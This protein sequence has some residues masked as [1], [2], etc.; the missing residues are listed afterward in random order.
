MRR[1]WFWPPKKTAST[2]TSRCSARGRNQYVEA[3]T[4]HDQKPVKKAKQLPEIIASIP[5]CAWL[6]ASANGSPKPQR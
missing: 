1:W 3:N 5:T 6:L 4:R 2:W